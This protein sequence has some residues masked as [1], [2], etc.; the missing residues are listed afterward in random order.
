MRS[1][2]W[3]WL[4]GGVVTVVVAVVL[5]AATTAGLGRFVRV[6]VDTANMREGPG[7]RF[8][9]LWQVY[10]NFPLKIVAQR[11]EW[12]KTEDFL[13]DE[14]WIYASLTDAK[15]AVVVEVELANVRSG[16]G[17]NHPVRFTAQWGAAFQVLGQRGEW[18]K[19]ED[20]HGGHGWLHRG[21]VWGALN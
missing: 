3:R 8:A 10:E 6:K 17:T 2:G 16:P 15:P 5:T 1:S 14:A 11:K 4:T 13:G 9:V 7:T 12:L 18:L 21:L 20:A 19:V